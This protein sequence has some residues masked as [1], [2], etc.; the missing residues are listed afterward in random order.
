MRPGE[1]VA[2]R[3][4]ILGEAARGGMGTVY[5]A[6]DRLTRTPV[7]VKTLADV[8]GVSGARFAREVAALQALAHPAIVRY[9][10]HGPDFLVTEWLEGE[11]MAA[12]L[13]RGAL[14]PGQALRACAR[15]AEALAEAHRLG[16]VHRD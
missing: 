1:R 14:A 16:I 8:E 3:Y 10:A 6:L 13:E 9:L 7:A 15:V 12:A 4:E 2:G 11:T 5:R